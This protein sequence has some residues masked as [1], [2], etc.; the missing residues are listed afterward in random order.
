M[1]GR[2]VVLF[3]VSWFLYFC[4]EFFNIA[5]IR[6]QSSCIVVALFVFRSP[7]RVLTREGRGADGFGGG[8]EGIATRDNP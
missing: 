3:L 4:I 1:I 2:T 6:K 8:G 7:Q 5:L